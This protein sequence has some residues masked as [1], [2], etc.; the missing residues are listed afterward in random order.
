MMMRRT[1]I[2]IIDD[3][4]DDDDVGDNNDELISWQRPEVAQSRVI[5]CCWCL[6]PTVRRS[7]P[8]TDTTA[9]ALAP[10]RCQ[11]TM[12][13]G[14]QSTMYTGCQST[15]YTG[16]QTYPHIHWSFILHYTTLYY[17]Y[18]SHFFHPHALFLA[19]C[20]H[21]SSLKGKEKD[22]SKNF[23]V[24]IAPWRPKIESWTKQDQSVI[25]STDL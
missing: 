16:W 20:P 13:T 1:I 4:D 6:F 3:K 25:Q 17:D 18:Q 12:Y 11:S 22:V 8:T 10:A 7:F 21:Q 24:H 9:A 2:M 14:C 23:L 19:V 15:M 5:P